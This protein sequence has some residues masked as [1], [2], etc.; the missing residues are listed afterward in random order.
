MDAPVADEVELLAVDSLAAVDA[1]L[2]PVSLAPEVPEPELPEPELASELEE[3]DEDEP[4]RESV[5]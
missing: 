3:I 1:L 5:R 2:A 4:S